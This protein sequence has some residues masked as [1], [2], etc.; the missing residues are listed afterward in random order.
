MH[1][2]RIV[3]TANSNNAIPPR[4]TGSRPAPANLLFAAAATVGAAALLALTALSPARTAA[5][6][7]RV[8]RVPSDT[9]A[10]RKTPTPV[11]RIR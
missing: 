2:R 4:G 8:Y 11:E 5:G 6:S 10:D 3:N 1:R 9:C 7:G